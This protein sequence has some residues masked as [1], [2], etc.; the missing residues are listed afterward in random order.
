[1]NPT[2]PRGLVIAGGIALIVSYVL[3]RAFYL[4]SPA[5]PRSPVL[6]VA[7]VALIE[8]QLGRAVR[9]RLAG[10]PQPRPIM[11][12]AVARFAALARASSLAAAVVIGGWGGV[13]AYTAPRGQQPAVAGADTI[14]SV[15]GVVS[16]ALLLAAAL[17]L[18]Y[19]C[20]QRRR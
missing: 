14:T 1:M 9:A 4:N 3:V 11:P 8:A 20:R 10:R 19:G 18:E 12:I 16:G 5:L 7:V 15:L 6:S 2:R 13:L 17:W